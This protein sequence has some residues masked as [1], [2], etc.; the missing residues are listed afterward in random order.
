MALELLKVAVDENDSDRVKLAAIRRCLD[1]H[2]IKTADN[3]LV[4]GYQ[5]STLYELSCCAAEH[6][7]AE[8]NMFRAPWGNPAYSWSAKSSREQWIRSSV[9]AALRPWVM[10]SLTAVDR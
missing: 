9:T 10:S 7:V 1:R 5:C 6:F 2:I 4:A 8:S 3:R